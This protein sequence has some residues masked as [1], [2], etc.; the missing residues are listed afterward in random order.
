MPARVDQPTTARQRVLYL[1]PTFLS[2]RLHKLVRGV[3]VFDLQFVR[4]LLAMG[5]DVTLPAE[6]TW[7]A[8]FREHFAGVESL[9]GRL[10]VVYTPPLI[11]PLWNG[12][13][14]QALLWRRFD[15]CF[16]GNISRGMV[17]VVDVLRARGLVDRVVIQANRTA[18]PAVVR[19]IRR[20]GA[21]VVAVSGHVGGTFPSDLQPPV[22]VYY[23]VLDA[24]DF[25]PA[26]MD[27][28]G[29]TSATT[30][31]SD[32][33]SASGEPVNFFLLGKLDTPIKGVSTALEAWG[34]LAPEVRA[35]CRL[36]LASY[37]KPPTDLPEGVVA[38][39][40]MGAGEVPGFMRR[41]DVMI[42][43]SITETFCQG[44]VQAMLSGLA[45]IGREMPT[46]SEKLDAGAGL[47]FT[48]ARELADHITRLASDA[49]LRRTM[50]QA[51]RRTAL[52]RYVWHTPTFV[53]RYLLP[54]R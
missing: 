28:R 16:V 43:S 32:T 23:G 7:R 31:P 50:G 37:P 3:Q 10:R 51:A 27:A 33:G 30:A 48:T 52:E 47:T 36:H 19:A 49:E 40:W 29:A 13:A 6:V 41:M 5:Q 39:A 54:K 14:L 9:P 11:K 34:M 2:Y 45:S 17:P 22:A 46:I 18:K 8:R 44:L 21:Q 42:V 25:S 15:A 35:R 24:Q 26:P 1:A 12:L 38:Y 4:E 20:W 53:E